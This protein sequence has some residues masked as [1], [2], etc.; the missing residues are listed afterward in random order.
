MKKTFATLLIIGTIA[1]GQG[2]A[3]TV[4]VPANVV[5]T[6]KEVAITSGS[7]TTT[8]DLS[9][10]GMTCAMGCG[11]AIKNALAKLPGVSAT[12]IDFTGAEVA[13]HAVVTFDPARISD[14][15]LV[16]AVQAIHDGQYSVKQ[17]DVVKQVMSTGGADAPAA[18]QEEEVNASL[19]T[20]N[21][22]SI[23][24]LLSRLLRI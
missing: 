18:E 2:P 4:A 15:E 22:P 1:C 8:A 19:P 16:E 20:I 3:E 12:E 17:V 23:A 5:R 14:A 21:F 9:I 11:G 6:E 7:P 24:G 10:T 13:N